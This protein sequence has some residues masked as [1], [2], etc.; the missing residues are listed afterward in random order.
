MLVNGV[1]IG[2]LFINVVFSFM[3]LFGLLLL[4]GMLIKN[5]IVFVDEIDVCIC[6]GVDK[7][8]VV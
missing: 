5:V 3:V 7:V 6:D 4:F 8:D 2:F 1:V